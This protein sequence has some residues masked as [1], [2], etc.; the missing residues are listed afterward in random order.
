MENYGRASEIKLQ[1]GPVLCYQCLASLLQRLYMDLDCLAI[2]FCL[3]PCFSSRSY[4]VS[5]V[6]FTALD[7]FSLFDLYIECIFDEERQ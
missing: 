7:T 2:S 3:K 6:R 4:Y 5:T 1:D